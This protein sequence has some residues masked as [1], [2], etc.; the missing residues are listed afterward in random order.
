MVHTSLAASPLYE[1]LNYPT[2]GQQCIDFAKNSLYRIPGDRVQ[3]MFTF[4]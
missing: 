4:L 2:T 3:Y 1:V